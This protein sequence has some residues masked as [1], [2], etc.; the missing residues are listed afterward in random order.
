MP[1]IGM[2]LLI[3]IGIGIGIGIVNENENAIMIMDWPSTRRAM[4]C[5]RG[6]RSIAPA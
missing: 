4:R 5:R 1:L 6:M 3:G 2:I